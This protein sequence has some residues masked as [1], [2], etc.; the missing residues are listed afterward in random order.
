[1]PFPDYVEFIGSLN[2]HRV[3]YLIVGPHALAITRDPAK[4]ISIE[5]QG[6]VGGALKFCDGAFTGLRRR[7]AVGSHEFDRKVAV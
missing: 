7:P 4:T 3:R 2:E 5:A 6:T 1:M